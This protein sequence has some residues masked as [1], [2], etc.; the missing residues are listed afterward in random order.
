MRQ[1]GRNALPPV[2]HIRAGHLLRLPWTFLSPRFAHNLELT[3]CVPH[4]GRGMVSERK[5]GEDHFWANS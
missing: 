3:F 2:E 5:N 1:G 4:K